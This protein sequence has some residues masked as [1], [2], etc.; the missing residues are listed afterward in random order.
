[1]RL[2]KIGAKKEDTFPIKRILS[3]KLESFCIVQ[4]R[5]PFVYVLPGKIG[6]LDSISLYGS[7]VIERAKLSAVSLGILNMT[8][9]IIVV[10]H[11]CLYPSP[12]ILVEEMKMTLFLFALMKN[13]KIYKIYK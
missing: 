6:V 9:P 13:E 7:G 10:I 3:K 8:L 2:H 4:I 11:M 12:S 1:L 5:I